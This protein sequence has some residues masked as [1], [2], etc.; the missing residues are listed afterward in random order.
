VLSGVNAKCERCTEGCKQWE[1]VRVV[2]CPHFRERSNL[3]REKE[4]K[5]TRIDSRA[6]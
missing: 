4:A 3:H 6:R 2:Y 1:Q 5:I